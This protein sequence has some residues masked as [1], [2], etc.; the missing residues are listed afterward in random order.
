MLLPKLFVALPCSV[1]LFLGHLKHFTKMP[2]IVKQLPKENT[3]KQKKETNLIYCPS[4]PQPW[5]I[6]LPP[7]PLKPT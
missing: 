3:E 5:P 1:T 6:P 2:K 4:P 7:G